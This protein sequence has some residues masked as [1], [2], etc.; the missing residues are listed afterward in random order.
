MKP[1]ITTLITYLLFTTT[2]QSQTTVL[3][4]GMDKSVYIKTDTADKGFNYLIIRLPQTDFSKTRLIINKNNRLAF[5]KEASDKDSGFIQLL[6]KDINAGEIKL[7][8]KDKKIVSIGERLSPYLEDLLTGKDTILVTLNAKDNFKAPISFIQANKT[9][10]QQ[11]NAFKSKLCIQYKKDTTINGLPDFSFL[12]NQSDIDNKCDCG[13]LV[14]NNYENIYLPPCF[15]KKGNALSVRHQLLYDASQKD[16]LRKV[17]LFDIEKSSKKIN[18][19]CT[20]IKDSKFQV[21]SIQEKLK[22]KVGQLLAISVIAHKDSIIVIDSN[23]VNYFLDSADAVAKAFTSAVKKQT[24]TID[25]LTTDSLRP[26]KA[27]PEKQRS[28]KVIEGAITLN[29]DIIYYNNL[30]KNGDFIQEKYYKDLL[31][32]QLKIAEF[33]NLGSIPNSGSALATGIEQKIMQEKPDSMHY[34]Q[35][36]RILSSIAEQYEIA[37]N[38]TSNYRIFSQVLQVPNADEINF[39]IR[40]KNSEKPLYRHNFL[41]KGGWKIDF[42]SGVLMSGLNNV[43]YVRKSVRLTYRTDSAS[44]AVRDTTGQTIDV[45]NNKMNYNIAFLAHLYKRSGNYFNYGLATGVTFNNSE[46][47]MMLGGSAMFRMGNGRLAFVGGLAF[48]RQKV[49][50]AN[51]AQYQFSTAKFD[52]SKVYTLN[53]TSPQNRVPRFFEETNITTY[54]KLKSSWFA[55][56]TYNFAGIKL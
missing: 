53:A 29:G 26:E 52:E 37:L 13:T 50:D 38:R 23:Y 24:E 21:A 46:F 25:S 31:C 17:F 10:S 22:P 27:K 3:L 11:N 39:G 18:T 54:E 43:D 14:K 19:N 44:A 4:N 6:A 2:L 48:G 55:G 40:T 32:M 33:F 5:I 35:I 56:I 34:A 42:S 12:C 49:L 16:G 8:F 15:D 30:N 7:T 51:Q 1:I 9:E 41:I 20:A 45:N 47:M 28:L 36:C